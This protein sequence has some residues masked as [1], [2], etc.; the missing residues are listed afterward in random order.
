MGLLRTWRRYRI[1]DLLVRLAALE[2]AHTYAVQKFRGLPVESVIDVSRGDL[3]RNLNWE[4]RRLQ[5]QA[6]GLMEKVGKDG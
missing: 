3:F 1:N 5:T 6:L 4:I 2:S